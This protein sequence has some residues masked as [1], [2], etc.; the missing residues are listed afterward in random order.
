VI[1]IE[2]VTHHPLFGPWVRGQIALAGLDTR[3][4]LDSWLD[5]I[6]ASLATAPHDVLKRLN[7]S[8]VVNAAIADPEGARKTWGQLPEH[9][10]TP[11]AEMKFSNAGQ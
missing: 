6:H 2:A 10:V 9:R 7:E 1:A 4:P 3:M 11:S 5:V 8:F